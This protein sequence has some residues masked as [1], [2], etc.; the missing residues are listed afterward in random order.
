MKSKMS[1]SDANKDMICD[2]YISIKKEYD[3]LIQ[4]NDKLRHI[5]ECIY[6]KF[7]LTDFKE[8]R[9]EIDD[10]V[11]EYNEKSKAIVVPPCKKILPPEIISP[12]ITKKEQLKIKVNGDQCEDDIDDKFIWDD[13]N[14][15]DTFAHIKN[16]YSS[17]YDLDND[18]KTLFFIYKDKLINM[19][20]SEP[21]NQYYHKKS[22]TLFELESVVVEHFDKK[23]FMSNKQLSK[24]W[25][26]KKYFNKINVI[27]Y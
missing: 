9:L 6:E 24:K 2:E 15:E 12:Y 19:L 20:K 16:V 7:K 3:E 5:K 1:L 27:E 22:D 21:N 18:V 10:L 13:N 25:G 11:F 4:N 14:I 23:K 26:V 8:N 17:I